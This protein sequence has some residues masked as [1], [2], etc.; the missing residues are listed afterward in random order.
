[1]HSEIVAGT[2]VRPT[3]VYYV[4]KDLNRLWIPRNHPRRKRG[5]LLTE[6]SLTSLWTCLSKHKTFDSTP[7]ITWDDRDLGIAEG[8]K[9]LKEWLSL[10]KFVELQV[11]D[12]TDM[13]TGEPTKSNLYKIHLYENHADPE[14]FS[15]EPDGDI[16]WRFGERRISMSHSLHGGKRRRY[17]A[18]R[19]CTTHG[20]TAR[21]NKER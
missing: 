18:R 8:K 7:S 9:F 21:K 12:T 15:K 17:P 5:I 20:A 4:M 19:Y 3:N 10:G 1:M 13:N 14:L 2:N 11:V 16:S 6:N